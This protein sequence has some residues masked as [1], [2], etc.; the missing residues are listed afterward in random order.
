MLVLREYSM[1]V[2][3]QTFLVYK[4]KVEVEEDHVSLDCI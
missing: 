1:L 4:E 3:E 2:K